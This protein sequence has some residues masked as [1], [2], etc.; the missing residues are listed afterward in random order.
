MSEARA[1]QELNNQMLLAKAE[2][3]RQKA[4]AA[5]TEKNKQALNDYYINEEKELEKIQIE[6]N[7]LIRNGVNKK[8]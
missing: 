7:K 8:L 3:N 4:Q 6:V 2:E 1:K 5:Q